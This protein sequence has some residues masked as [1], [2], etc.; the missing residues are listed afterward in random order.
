MLEGLEATSALRRR[1]LRARGEEH[2]QIEHR[3]TYV[4][5][6]DFEEARV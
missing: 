5:R 6:T 4:T 1:W 2:R 3:S